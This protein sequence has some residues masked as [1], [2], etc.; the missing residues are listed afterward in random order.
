MIHQHITIRVGMDEWNDENLIHTFS[1]FL[2]LFYS[3]ALY[4][5]SSHSVIY[6]ILL[7]QKCFV[8]NPYP[9][10]IFYQ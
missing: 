10:L 5:V 8:I 2:F 6:L 4:V 9:S 1:A 3:F 7:I